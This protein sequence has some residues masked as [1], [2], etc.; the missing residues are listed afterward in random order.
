V[1]NSYNLGQALQPV[2]GATHLS[3]MQWRGLRLKT[4]LALIMCLSR[5]NTVNYYFIT[6]GSTDSE[7]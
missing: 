2:V 5:G 7:G 6:L 4:R 3:T 1:H